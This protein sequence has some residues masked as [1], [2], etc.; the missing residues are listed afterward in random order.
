MPLRGVRIL[1]VEEWLQL[2]LAT[3]NLSEMGAEVIRVETLP[4]LADREYF[5]EV[6]H[7]ILG[8]LRY[9]GSGFR[10]DGE[11]CTDVSPA[12]LLGQHNREIY[13]DWLGRSNEALSRLKAAGVI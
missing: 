12:P 9:T 6:T 5:Q 2:P 1:T 4:Q 13:C 3:V 8:T 11:Q 7:P 10:V